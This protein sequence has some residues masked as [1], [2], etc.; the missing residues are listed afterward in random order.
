LT[1][2]FS[3][4]ALSYKAVATRLAGFDGILTLQSGGSQPGRPFHLPGLFNVV[5][6]RSPTQF[7][8]QTQTAKG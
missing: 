8:Q 3:T 4:W 5:E 2:S 6:H 7:L 1:D